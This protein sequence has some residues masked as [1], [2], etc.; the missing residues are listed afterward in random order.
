MRKE[1]K[2]QI[3]GICQ[4]ARPEIQ[5]LAG[6]A[7]A[8][9]MQK[10]VAQTIF[11]DANECA[12]DPFVGASGLS[13]YPEQQPSQL[14]D[15]FCRWLDVSSRNL[16]ITR[17][18]DE[19]IDC[20]M[21]AFCTPAVDNVVI[22]P[23]TFA[24]YAQSAMLQGVK[25]M[26]AGLNHSFDLDLDAIAAAV[27]DNTKMIFVCSPN[28][29]TG[30]LMDRSKIIELC[31]LYEGQ[32]LVVVDE[33]YIEFSNVTSMINNLDHYSNLVVLRTLS[34][35][36]AAAGLRCGAAIA[37][38]DVTELLQK[39]LA[40][41]PLPQPVIAAA[42]TI[43][44]VTN[45]NKL[46]EKR[47]EIIERRSDYE[48]R[49]LAL[50]DVF[51]VLPSDA[52]YLLLIVRDANDFCRRAAANNIILRNQSHQ[53]G[54]ANSV[55]V[56]IGSLEDMETLF[57]TLEG[58]TVNAAVKQR[59]KQLTR[60]TNETTISVKVN[61]DK[62]A[63]VRINTGIGFYNH[64]LDQIAKHGGFSLELDCAGDL[65]VDPHHSVED[66]A[67]ALGQA[68]RAALGDK[69]GIGR[70]GFVLPMDES[71]VQVAL[72]FGGRFYL[73]FKADFPENHVGDLPCDL[74]PH[75]FYSLAENLQANLHI[76][77][78][79][80]N[81]HHMVE[82]CFKG[83]GRALRQAIRVDGDEMPSTKGTL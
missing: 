15:A 43:L 51:M 72:D 31:R 22:C 27:D 82:A 52:N 11:L 73:D 19:A 66:C 63:P 71:Q 17:G 30:N 60:K 53:P 77:V 24:M 57:A 20:L 67:I 78:T 39:V 4:R 7:S 45:I 26:S 16:T 9:S 42:L 14:V 37:R 34:K 33:T 64:M 79:G 48:T 44:D 13:R 25:V 3:S 29:P 47:S 69:T 70:Y 83:F 6:Y 28:N 41:Y 1:M 10:P 46:A 35:S 65:E 74:V 61:L 76:A 32:A 56:S 68:I 38:A 59:A 55:R 81:T 49:F 23:P 8:R 62:T 75:V 2:S 40:P 5:S 12:Y 21:R 58:R 50:D 80:E 18:A 54:L 36:H